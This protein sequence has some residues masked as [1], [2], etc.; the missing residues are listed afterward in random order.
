MP[1]RSAQRVLED[2]VES[3]L[4]ALVPEDMEATYTLSPVTYVSGERSEEEELTVLMSEIKWHLSL[5]LSREIGGKRRQM[6]L[7]GGIPL[8]MC[9]DGDIIP[10]LGL[11][12]RM[13]ADQQF[14][15]LMADDDLDRTLNQ[16]VLEA[17]GD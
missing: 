14:G 8:Q 12:D 13:W 15:W 5:H 17:G 1:V 7:S 16:V 11:V 3:A 4:I 6:V 2:A 10:V 9:S